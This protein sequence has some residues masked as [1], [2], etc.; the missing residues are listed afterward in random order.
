MQTEKEIQHL[1]RFLFLKGVNSD[2]SVSFFV[3]A[4]TVNHLYI[5]AKIR[6]GLFNHRLPS[7][8]LQNQKPSLPSVFPF[9]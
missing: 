9:V 2:V 3:K 8:I 7:Q 6:L 1:L 5:K 4:N